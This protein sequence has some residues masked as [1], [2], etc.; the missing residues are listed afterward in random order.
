MVHIRTAIAADAQAIAAV[1]FA[2]VHHGGK[3][4]Y[5]PEVLDGWSS[6]PDETHY[7]KVRQSIMK[8]EEL[9]VVADDESAGVVGF[10]S[11]VPTMHELWSVYVDPKARRQGIGSRIVR[12]LEQL[13]LRRGVLQLRLAASLNAEA[14]YRRAGYEWVGIGSI[15]LKGGTE[16]ACVKMQKVLRPTRRPKIAPS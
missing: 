7:E 15:P 3:A 8:G 10:G 5:P 13:A 1:H 14:F 11:V 4:F 12:R 16:M 2:A 9:F 6:E